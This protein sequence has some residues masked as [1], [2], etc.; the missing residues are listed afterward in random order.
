VGSNPTPSAHVIS[1]DCDTPNPG[2]GCLRQ[3]ERFR[4]GGSRGVIVAHMWVRAYGYDL[5]PRPLGWRSRLGRT[6]RGTTCPDEGPR[7]SPRP[8]Q[9]STFLLRGLSQQPGRSPAE[10]TAPQFPT[11]PTRPRPGTTRR[12]S[13]APRAASPSRT[14]T[15]RCSMAWSTPRHDD[16]PR[17]VPRRRRSR[18]RI[19]NHP[20]RARSPP[21]TGAWTRLPGRSVGIHSGFRAANGQG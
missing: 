4:S 6:E 21:L 9:S 18:S 15:R 12:P 11:G 17:P 2:A 20:V 10:L 13:F 1:R 3:R 19:L 16:R 14:A 7:S 5:Y 8:W